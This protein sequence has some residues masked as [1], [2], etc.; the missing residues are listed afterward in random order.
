VLSSIT[1]L[2]KLDD[3]TNCDRASKTSAVQRL[4]KNQTPPEDGLR[5]ARASLGTTLLVL[6]EA[7]F[8]DVVE[9]GV[10]PS[11]TPHGKDASAKSSY[12]SVLTADTM[13]RNASGIIVGAQIPK[14]ECDSCGLW[15]QRNSIHKHRTRCL[16]K[17]RESY[18]SSVSSKV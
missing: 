18:A 15:F 13:A 1:E 10:Q 9:Q 6:S 7:A 17:T 11:D 8:K 3:A 2:P 12:S 16:K 5:R 14:L 4:A